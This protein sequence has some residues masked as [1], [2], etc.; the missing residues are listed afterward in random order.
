MTK[1]PIKVLHVFA[2]GYKDCFGGTTLRWKFNFSNW[3]DPNVRHYILDTENGLMVPAQDA[4]NFEYP[5]VQKG[6]SRWD[7]GLWIF[8]LF[9]YL[10][11]RKHEYDVLHVHVLWWASLLIGLWSK[12]HNIPSIYESVL[13]DSDTP[14]GIYKHKLGSVQINLL[15]TYQAILAI[16]ENIAKDYREFGFL[17]DQ[18][19]T[20]ANCVDVNLFS[21][22]KS[23]K[24]RED[25][26]QELDVPST[27]VVLVFV[28]GI[29][30]RKGV[31]VLLRAFI[32]ASYSHPSLYLLLIGS[33]N[34][35]EYPFIDEDFVNNL[36][37]LLR[38]HDLQ[39][40][41]RLIGL[42]QNR[43]K[44]SKIYRASD[45]FVFPSRKEGM[46]NAMLEA[47]ASGLPVIVSNL[48]VFRKIITHEE[49]GMIVPLDDVT[50]L[51]NMIL[52]LCDD[53]PS[54]QRIGQNARRYIEENHSFGLWQQQIVKLYR[55][56]LEH[57]GTNDII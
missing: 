35:S 45:I 5:K 33:K 23:V 44:L 30:E 43:Q 42:V 19:F 28:G 16:A 52:S 51:K 48:S 8:P 50:A 46:P 3:D 20:L 32:D 10:R 55:N 37:A 4:M 57:R 15:K 24:E 41:A 47:M 25:I 12:W 31:D 22:I 17:A 36:T 26:R 1:M 9:W 27:A 54:I 29:V 11:K 7:R 53:T 2:L 6:I 40:R 18:V 56:L 34:K 13:F 39:D 38:D 14:S 21:P 49:N